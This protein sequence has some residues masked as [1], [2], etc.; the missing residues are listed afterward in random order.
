MPLTT[1]VV[2][3]LLVF[4]IDDTLKRCYNYF[5]IKLNEDSRTIESFD[6]N[7]KKVD[8]AKLT[9]GFYAKVTHAIDYTAIQASQSY[10]LRDEQEKYFEQEKGPIGANRQ[11]CWSED[12]KNGRLFIYFVAMTLASYVKHVW[13]K[14]NLKKQF[15]SFTE[16]LDEMRPIRCIEYKGRAKHITPFVGK[17]LDIVKAFA[18]EIPEGCDAKYKSKKSHEKRVGRP[19]KPKVFPE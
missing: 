17:Q 13:N 5:D 2:I 9:S 8:D 10:A 6:I 15:C 1:A 16:M 11:R 18:F 19:A 12:G 14:T 7:K 3:C 4:P